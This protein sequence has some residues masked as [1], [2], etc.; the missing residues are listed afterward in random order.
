MPIDNLTLVIGLSSIASAKKP[1]RPI[2]PPPVYNNGAYVRITEF[3][4]SG[5]IEFDY[6]WD[7]SDKFASPAVSYWIG[8]YDMT[9]AHYVWAGENYLTAPAGSPGTIV[10]DSL[11]LNY[12]DT[13]PLSSGQY[14]IVFFVRGASE[15]VASIAAEF[16]IP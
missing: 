11:R 4:V 13:I 10:W 15:N 9:H 8:L 1:P 16:I 3:P 7:D 12:A 6:G 14:A 5:G 2:I